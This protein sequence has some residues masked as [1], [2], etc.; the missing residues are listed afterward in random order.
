MK[1][2]RRIAS[3]GIIIFCCRLEMA[4]AAE[5]SFSQF[6]V[7]KTYSIGY[8]NRLP[9]RTVGT[10]KNVLQVLFANVPEGGL[11]KLKSFTADSQGRFENRYAS[12]D[13]TQCR[14]VINTTS[15]QSEKG[16]WETIAHEVGHSLIF[17]KLTPLEL[18][19]IA[20]DAGG[21]SMKSTPNTFY[22]RSFFVRFFGADMHGASFP[23][24][25]SYTNVHEWLAENFAKY[26]L[27]KA[28]KIKPVNLKLH[29]F[30]DKLFH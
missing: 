26:V 6:Q 15:L 25:Y 17:S 22:D 4:C 20:R 19:R 29:N 7:N 21:W 12:Y 27:S 10:I 28:N 23:T 13:E 11:V 16:E 3:V 30:F 18:S 9:E 14:V 24:L 8:S 1:L 5:E 2:I